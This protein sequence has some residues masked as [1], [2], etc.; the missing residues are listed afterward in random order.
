MPKAPKGDHR[1]RSRRSRL[2]NRKVDTRAVLPTMTIVCDD[3]VTA[4]K[5]FHCL[6]RVVK[7]V[8]K[9]NVLAASQ[10]K[11]S[12][13]AVVDR[14][15]DEYER[16][17]KDD[18]HDAV[19]VVI[20]ME[21]EDHHRQQAKQEKKR[22]KSK[23]VNV[24]LSNPCFEVWT[25]LHLEDTGR[26]F[27]G[28]AAVIGRL[29]Q[30]WKD[31]FGKSFDSKTQIDFEKIIARRHEACKRAKSH[32]QDNDQSWTEVY[33]ILEAIESLNPQRGSGGA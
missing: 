24:A 12:A 5:Y 10:G 4:P 28:C 8:A 6:Q 14:A 21:Q 11:T 2:D 20:D 15:I 29:K 7:Q 32:Q 19:W 27:N 13:R 30:L 26:N 1:G 23:G 3:S 17:D 9:L 16:L 33:K 18:D 25:L 31:E 22:A